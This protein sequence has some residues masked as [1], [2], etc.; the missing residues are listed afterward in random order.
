[1]ILKIKSIQSLL[2]IC[3][4]VKSILAI[5]LPLG[6]D[7]SY[8]LLYGEYFQWHFYDHPFMVGAALKFVSKL[9]PF[10][11]PFI[12]RI[13]FILASTVTTYFVFLIGKD[14]RGERV[15]LLAAILLSVTPYFSLIAG[16]FVMPDPLLMMF[17]SIAIY[18]AS[19]IL[20]KVDLEKN[21]Q[22]E[23]LICFGIFAGLAMASKIHAVLLWFGFFSYALLYRR[24]IFKNSYFWVSLILSFLAWTPMIWWNYQNNWINFTFYQSRV[25]ANQG[26]QLD[27]FFREFSGQILY[28]NP[29]VWFFIL[30]FG[31]ILPFKKLS[32][33]SKM[34]LLFFSI[35]LIL[36][37]FLLSL[38]KETL[39]HWSGPSYLSLILLG[40]IGIED[41]S[42][43]SSKLGF[44]LRSSG[45][46]IFV[47]L[48]LGIL[49]IF[50]Y[51]GTFGK[52][53]NA[54]TYGQQ[55]FTLD[56]YGWR[57][58]GFEVA[59]KI[60]ALQWS[61]L[62]IYA[63][64][65]FPASQI[66]EYI[67][68][69]SGN[70]LYGVGDVKRIHHYAWVNVERGGM[71]IGDTALYI[72]VS[73]FPTDPQKV[74]AKYFNKIVCIDSVPQYRMGKISRYFHLFL[75]SKQ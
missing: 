68:K 44:W 74:Y 37:V 64:N 8:Y 15:G 70:K 46:T 49:L 20:L 9:L 21:I 60:K 18:F 65:W 14:L 26:L 33:K 51:P 47:L 7:E 36:L 72:G 54:R 13:P 28:Q 42:R 66:D 16:F 75:M 34:L 1:M 63:D 58:T 62:P 55:D 25:D 11:F 53:A 31:L 57:Q 38:F 17:W 39:P 2:L 41:S 59:K 67:C 5:V 43:W 50:F 6:I 29:I 22:N 3:L 45:I 73:N 12:Y 23:F 48:S 10:D 71:P 27:Y 56:M 30:V 52:K 40:V 61:H 24:A 35:P 19:K 4:V 32:E 69:K